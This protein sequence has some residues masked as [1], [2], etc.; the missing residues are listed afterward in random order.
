MCLALP[1]WK[2]GGLFALSRPTL[3]G[4]PAQ[5]PAGRSPFA[6]AGI[7][8]SGLTSFPLVAPDDWEDSVSPPQYGP[9]HRREVSWIVQCG[10]FLC[11]ALIEGEHGSP[12]GASCE[13][14]A[15]VQKVLALTGCEHG[16]PGGAGLVKVRML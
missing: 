2:W 1:A 8:G 10:I 5:L 13:I 15:A 3:Q 14:R 12:M 7:K 9:R 11:K 16:S 6:D 4:D